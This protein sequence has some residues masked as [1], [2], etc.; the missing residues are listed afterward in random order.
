MKSASQ[1]PQVV[2]EY[3]T[4]EVETGR[5]VDPFDPSALPEV[6]IGRFGMIPKNNQPGKWQL[7]VDLFHPEGVSVNDGIEPELCTPSYT[8][9]DKA[10]RRVCEQGPKHH[11]GEI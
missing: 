10:V 7:I 11:D 8:S 5:V 4:R 9:V 3:L 2:D 6:S 1:N